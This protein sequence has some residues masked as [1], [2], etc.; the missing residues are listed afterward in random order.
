MS[1][2]QVVSVPAN[3]VVQGH[4]SYH[5]QYVHEAERYWKY[6]PR[7]HSLIIGI[8]QIVCGIICII[9]GGCDFSVKGLYYETGYGIW[10]GICPII[11]G[12]L[13]IACS[14]IRKKSLIVAHLVMSILAGVIAIPPFIMAIVAAEHDSDDTSTYTVD[15][16]SYF[17]NDNSNG[18]RDRR[19]AVECLLAITLAFEGVLAVWVSAMTC[20]FCCCCRCCWGCC[21]FCYNEHYTNTVHD[22][23]LRNIK[24]DVTEMV[25]Y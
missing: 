13:G 12:V 2:V 19:L 24:N 20:Q 21:C 25:D 3:V 7:R 10:G 16:Y 8:L 14:F 22:V 18:L 15:G 1:H 23:T 4:H 6:Y 5:S 11:A 17:S 9:L